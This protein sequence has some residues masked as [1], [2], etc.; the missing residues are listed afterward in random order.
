M[1]RIRP[2]DVKDETGSSGPAKMC[3][4]FTSVSFSGSLKNIIKKRI[5]MNVLLL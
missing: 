2:T 4:C 1:R 3:V 5:I